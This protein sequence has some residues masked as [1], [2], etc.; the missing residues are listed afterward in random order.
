M[1][2]IH[3]VQI[4]ISMRQHHALGIG[5]GATGIEKLGHGV[6]VDGRNIGTT[7]RSGGE[8]R[9]VVLRNEP[10]LLPQ[11]LPTAR[12]FLRS[13]DLCGKPST[14]GR[15]CLSRNRIVGPGVVED[16]SKFTGGQT[17]I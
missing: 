12:N 3:G 15:N 2:H 1:A 14:N 5:A 7:R 11:G 9:I 4:N 10:G 17:D 16:V 6:F 8:Q 13:S